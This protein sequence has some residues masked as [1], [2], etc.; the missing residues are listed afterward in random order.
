LAL[1]KDYELYPI[2]ITRVKGNPTTEIN[3]VF[4]FSRKENYIFPI[5][6]LIIETARHI[7]TRI[8]CLD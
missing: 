7:Y 5:D 2:K 3:V 4:G 1:A 8:H 6:E